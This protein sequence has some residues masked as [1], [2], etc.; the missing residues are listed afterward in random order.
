M[1]S[2]HNWQHRPLH[3]LMGKTE[4]FPD[5]QPGVQILLDFRGSCSEERVHENSNNTI[6]CSTPLGTVYGAL[7]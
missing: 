6:K 5:N 2:D 7:E 3:N 1:N 4:M